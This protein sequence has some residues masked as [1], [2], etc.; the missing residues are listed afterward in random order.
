M[1]G[2]PNNA[3]GTPN[4]DDGA[5]TKLPPKLPAPFEEFV[6]RP[7]ASTPQSGAKAPRPTFQEFSRGSQ[8]QST[9]PATARNPK[10][11]TPNPAPTTAA[12][13]PTPQ[14]AASPSPPAPS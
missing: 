14:P 13:N 8:S 9:N 10:P 6:S 5:G 1:G 4:H 2:P 7:S 3:S 11:A 12:S